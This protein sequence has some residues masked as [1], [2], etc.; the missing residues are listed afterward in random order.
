MTGEVA[1]WDPTLL[2]NW[3]VILSSANEVAVVE[4]VC[5]ACSGPVKAE[6]FSDGAAIGAF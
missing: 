5:F 6:A 4:R 1:V 3:L 2:I